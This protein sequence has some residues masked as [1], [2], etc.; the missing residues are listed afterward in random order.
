MVYCYQAMYI[1]KTKLERN[2]FKNEADFVECKWN[3]SMYK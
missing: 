3:K 1:S 2:E